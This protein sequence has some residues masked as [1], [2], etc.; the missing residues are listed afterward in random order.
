VAQVGDEVEAPAGALRR[1]GLC[2]ALALAL[3]A[4]GVVLDRLGL[5]RTVKLSVVMHAPF[6]SMAALGAFVVHLG[7]PRPA[8]ERF[9]AAAIG[10]LAEAFLAALRL[11]AGQ[12]PQE[13]A[14][15]IG[16]GLGAASVLFLGVALLR[17]RGSQRRAAA[18]VLAQGLL[19]PA[20]VF[21]AAPFLDLTVKLH[22]LTL[23]GAA[24][25]ADQALGLQPSFA[26]ARLLD[27]SEWLVWPVAAAYDA[28]PL[29]FALLCVGESRSRGERPAVDA[30][31]VFLLAG[32]LGSVCYHLVPVAGPNFA[33]PD[34]PRDV[35]P[36]GVPTW[37]AI[38]KAP[39]NGVP[40][41]HMA[42]AL[43]LFARGRRLGLAAA[44]AGAILCVLTFGA[45]LG[46][47]EHYLCD[48]VSSVPFTVGL[49]VL[50]STRRARARAEWRAALGV[51]SASFALYLAAL[52]F[53]LLGALPTALA[54][55]VMAL[56]TGA[57]LAAQARLRRALREGPA[58][59]A[60]LP[61]T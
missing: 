33:F 57:P 4:V 7:S 61:S 21:A 20:F 46:L 32:L 22:P 60:A 55:G 15:E 14:L 25:Q 5:A 9:A 11:R 39:R 10:A 13:V 45:T 38:A 34:F 49:L 12:K 40:S 59:P 8:V 26:I 50:L 16:I 27:T 17:T 19:L 58:A 54:W 30:P 43:L 18:T 52:R 23:D 36:A 1:P 41:L 6:L 44:A 47:G 31:S 48:L 24:F 42:W 56:V 53:G 35:D 3:I 51:A 28:L 29:A 2:L 37:L